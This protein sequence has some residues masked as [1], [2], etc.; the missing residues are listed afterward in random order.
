MS[1]ILEIKKQNQAESQENE[2]DQQPDRGA[3]PKSSWTWALDIT[4]GIFLFGYVLYFCHLCAAYNLGHKA[5][6]DV[7]KYIESIPPLVIIHLPLVS[8]SLVCIADGINRFIC[9]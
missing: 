2:D 3:S 5:E 4:L 6:A 1:C 8:I 9:C 7:R